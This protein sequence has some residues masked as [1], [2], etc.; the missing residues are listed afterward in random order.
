MVVWL[1]CPSRW[2]SILRGQLPHSR[3]HILSQR[4]ALTRGRPDLEVAVVRRAPLVDDRLDLDELVIDGEP[5]RGFFTPSARVAV[6]SS[7]E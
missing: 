6:D 2:Y 1:P 4:V 5:P 7:R 3:R